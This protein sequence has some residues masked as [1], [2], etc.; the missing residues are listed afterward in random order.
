[1]GWWLCLPSTK[2]ENYEKHEDWIEPINEYLGDNLFVIG[3]AM[4]E[5]KEFT[6]THELDVDKIEYTN[7]Y[8]DDFVTVH[9]VN[10]DPVPF[11]SDLGEDVDIKVPKFKEKHDPHDPDN[12]NKTFDTPNQRKPIDVTSFAD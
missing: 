12:W 4:S 5:R 7:G 6:N 10:G 11:S 8:R 9:D 3:R 2:A 1:M